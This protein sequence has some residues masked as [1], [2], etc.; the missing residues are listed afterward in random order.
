[1]HDPGAA[2]YM[3]RALDSATGLFR[4]ITPWF[5]ALVASKKLPPLCLPEWSLI[6]SEVGVWGH[7]WAD[8]SD[9]CIHFYA[10]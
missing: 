10:E 4:W 8:L 1:M 9:H 2:A 5:G 3:K 6:A 7:D